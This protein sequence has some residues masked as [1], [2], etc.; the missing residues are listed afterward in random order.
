MVTLVQN[1][2]FHLSYRFIKWLPRLNNDALR[3]LRVKETLVQLQR[4]ELVRK[5][6]FLSLE[7]FGR[8]QPSWGYPPAYEAGFRKKLA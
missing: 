2:A 5:A 7:K 6:D 3:E 4:E 8:P 1:Q